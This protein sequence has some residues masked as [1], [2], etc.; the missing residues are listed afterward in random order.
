VFSALRRPDLTHLTALIVADDVT[1]PIPQRELAQRLLP[2]VPWRGP[3]PA[4][5]WATLVRSDRARE[6]LAWR[7]KYR[8]RGDD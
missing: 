7:P 4:N 5:E 2:D 1:S 6:A 8:W 3:E